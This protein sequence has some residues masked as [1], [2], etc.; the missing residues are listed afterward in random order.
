MST[1]LD[2]SNVL[3]GSTTTGSGRHFGFGAT[4][5]GSSEV[6]TGPRVIAAAALS[7]VN[8]VITA[9][10]GS[11]ALLL[12]G[13]IAVNTNSGT[14]WVLYTASANSLATVIADPG[15][16]GAIAVTASGTCRLVSAA[17]E[18]RT[19]AIP[20]FIGQQVVLTFETDGGDVVVTAASA[21]NV[22]GNTKM[23][24]GDIGDTISLFGAIRGGTR[25]WSVQ[26]NDG[27]ALS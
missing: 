19:L 2:G 20:T 17:A 16:A 26:G 22:A 14:T 23:T 18:T 3:I 10:A 9:P 12:D 6:S 11:L 5:S 7:A 27:V 24:F 21:I 4:G 8:G 15:N 1:R 13:T 25:Q